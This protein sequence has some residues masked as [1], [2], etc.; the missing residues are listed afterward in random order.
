MA[1]TEAAPTHISMNG[2]GPKPSP[3]FGIRGFNEM[4]VCTGAGVSG[5]SL[6]LALSSIVICGCAIKYG[7]A[8]ALRTKMPAVCGQVIFPV[9]Y[10][11]LIARVPVAA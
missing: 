10:Y 9:V 7:M 11:S 3:V 1:V 4:P 5:V 2:S 6:F 8:L